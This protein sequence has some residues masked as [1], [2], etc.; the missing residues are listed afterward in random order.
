L[1]LV[2]TFTLGNHS[3]SSRGTRDHQPANQNYRHAID[4]ARRPLPPAINGGIGKSAVPSPKERKKLAP[5][6][7][8]IGGPAARSEDAS[9]EEF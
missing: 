2:G 7:V 9:F 5:T 3:E 8:L 6:P 4:T 1:Q